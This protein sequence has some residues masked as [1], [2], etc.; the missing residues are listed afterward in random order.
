[1]RIKRNLSVAKETVFELPKPL[2]LV[3]FTAGFVAL[4]V[5]VPWA[6]HLIGG[7]VAGRTFLPMHFFVLC[8]GLIL[9]W[10]SGLVAGLLSP[11]ISFALTGMPPAVVLL[12]LTLEITTY[13][14][15]SGLLRRRLGRNV[16]LPLI[17]AL[18]A[19]RIVVMI[20]VS[21]TRVSPPFSYLA[22]AVI[23]GLPGIA[24]QIALIPLVAKLFTRRTF[25]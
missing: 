18:L 5:G 21:L 3:G 4:S 7:P 19:G 1:L 2:A 22:S 23:A 20:A 8:A 25:S 10:R 12:P 15:V 14:L 13:G 11:I 6:T 24:I 9:G 16:W 17:G